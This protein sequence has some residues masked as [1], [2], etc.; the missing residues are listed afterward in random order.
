[1][2]PTVLFFARS[3][4]AE[5]FPHLTSLRYRSVYATMTLEEKRMVIAKGG[6]VVGCFEEEFDE[7]KSEAISKD[8]LITSLASDRYLIHFSLPD[9]LTILGKEKQFWQNILSGYSPVAVINEAVAIEISE[10]LYIETKKRSIKYLGWLHNPIENYFYWMTTPMHGSMDP[11][12]FTKTPNPESIQIARDYCLK[13]E[14]NYK[15]FYVRDLKS[16]FNLINILKDIWALGITLKWQSKYASSKLKRY[17]IFGADHKFYLWRLTLPFRSIFKRYDDLNKCANFEIIFYPLHFEPEATLYY[18][19]EYYSDQI[20]TIYNISKCLNLNQVLVVKEHPQQTG[21]LLTKG[22]QQLKAKN[23]NLIFLP[24]EFNSQDIIRK[25]VAIITLTSTVGLEALALGKPVLIMGN[26]FYD[27]Y[28]DLMK[29]KHFEELRVVIKSGNYVQPEKETLIHFLA[30]LLQ[31]S[32][33]GNP[34]PHPG[35]YS[36]QN[37]QSI[38]AAIETDAVQ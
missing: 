1:M 16:R 8:Y 5:F 11:S 13:I 9:R 20:G 15:P 25:S 22:Y 34:I 35:L 37:I 33:P 2:L 18:M 19:A 10:V 36:P 23:S 3:Y 29:I 31:Y 6:Q 21:M 28:R 4:Q 27:C 17:A 12:I 14:S 26:I 38:V 24:A 30:C 7:L 32:Y